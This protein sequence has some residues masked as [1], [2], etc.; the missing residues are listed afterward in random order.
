VLNARKRKELAEIPADHLFV[1][2]KKYFI[3]NGVTYANNKNMY[4]MLAVLSLCLW[5]PGRQ[6]LGAVT[7]SPDIWPKCVIARCAVACMPG[8]TSGNWAIDNFTFLGC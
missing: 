1:K 8:V 7:R 5:R 4:N 3:A 2:F 6:Q